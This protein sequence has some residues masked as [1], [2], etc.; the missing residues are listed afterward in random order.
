MKRNILNIT[1]AALV[2]GLVMLS[3][4][5]SEDSSS[6]GS[7]GG[8]ATVPAN[9][10]LINTSS[11]A[12]SSLATAALAGLSVSTIFAVETTPITTPR[13]IIDSLLDRINSRIEGKVNIVTGVDLSSEFCPDGGSAEGSE[14]RT[15]T[16]YVA[17]L[18][19]N[20][21][22][23]GA[24]TFTGN[25]SANNTFS[26]SPGPYTTNLSGNLTIIDSSGTS[27]FNGFSFVSNGDESSGAYTISTFT[28]SLSLSTGG[29][30]LAQLTQPLVGNEFSPCELT[31]GQL[32]LTGASGS[33]AR[34]TINPDGSAVMEFHPGN[35]NFTPTD[36]SPLMC[37]I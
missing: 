33:Q 1:S 8:G 29:G 37:L 4:C 19:L 17:S 30:F 15:S 23:D 2:S 7:S 3:A 16:S 21:C 20:A 9:A 24:L 22:V 35:G 5:S 28:F 12:E 11:A 34:A 25:F 31:S 26:I 10:T 36:N 18:N 13:D 32:L 27:A 6:S 14:T